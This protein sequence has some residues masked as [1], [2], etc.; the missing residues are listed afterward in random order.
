MAFIDAQS[1]GRVV[2][3]ICTALPVDP[4][5][6]ER[7]IQSQRIETI[8]ILVFPDSGARCNNKLMLCKVHTLMF[9]IYMD[10]IY[11]IYSVF[12]S[13]VPASIRATQTLLNTVHICQ[14]HRIKTP[15]QETDWFRRNY[16]LP[17]WT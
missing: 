15:N 12:L 7:Y 6:R 8:N 3:L 4:P 16:N 1:C 10:V 5:S 9:K 17:E 11:D 2:H 14:A 13:R